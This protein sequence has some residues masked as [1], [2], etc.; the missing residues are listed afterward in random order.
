MQAAN[1]FAF[2]KLPM[3]TLVALISGCELINPSDPVPSYVHIDEI[4]VDPIPGTG[5][6]H[7]KF[8]E[9]WIYANDNYVGTYSIPATVPLLL[10]GQTELLFFAGI[11]V[12]G[13][14]SAADF[15]PFL[16]PHSV[17]AT[18][19]PGT[20]TQIDMHTR[21]RSNA[22]VAYIEDFES[23]HRITDDLDDDPATFVQ[24]ITAGTFE[25]TGSGRILLDEDA[26]IIRVASVP[27]LN[28][29]PV[30]GSPVYLELH[31]KNTVEFS[32]GLV[33]HGPVIEP[34]SVSII[35]LRAREDWNK[36]YIELTPALQASQLSAYQVL[37]VAAHDT[38]REQSEIYLDN[39]KIVHIAQ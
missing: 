8:G 35:V 34:A 2:K 12:N 33:G 10:E 5:T 6:I 16:E 9:V 36:I 31:Y 25:G 28:T 27:L 24:R 14:Q 37:F 7:H 30:N 29:L 38:S 26:D 20:T 21:Y 18:F 3:V 17:M 15:Y 32:V 1:S 22:T 39:L 19:D 11:R 13:I 4:T 23:A